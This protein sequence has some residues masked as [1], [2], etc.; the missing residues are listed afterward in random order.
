MEVF[1]YGFTKC[2]VLKLI[3]SLTT[4]HPPPH[5]LHEICGGYSWHKLFSYEPSIIMCYRLLVVALLSGFHWRLPTQDGAVC[6]NQ[7][8]IQNETSDTVKDVRTGVCI[9]TYCL[10]PGG[11]EWIIA[12]AGGGGALGGQ[13]ARVVFT[14]CRRHR[15]TARHGRS[16][17]IPARP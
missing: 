14:C 16:T 10:G 11:E 17:W 13:I 1:L 7:A 4:C 3:E 9:G 5:L 15:T 2:S 8:P 6:A 12:M